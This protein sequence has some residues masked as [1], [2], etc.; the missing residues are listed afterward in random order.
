MRLSSSATY[1]QPAPAPVS[2]TAPVA[3]ATG[4]T[5]RTAFSWGSNRASLYVLQ[6]GST[7]LAIAR[8]NLH[9]GGPPVAEDKHCAR[10]WIALQHLATNPA[11]PALVEANRTRGRVYSLSARDGRGP[12]GGGRADSSRDIDVSWLSQAAARIARLRLLRLARGVVTRVCGFC[13]GRRDPVRL[14]SI[15]GILPH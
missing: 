1:A 9:R 3:G 12:Y 10:Q 13:E 14:L 11:E 2:L 8:Q 15:A 6:V 5:E 7:C 4:I